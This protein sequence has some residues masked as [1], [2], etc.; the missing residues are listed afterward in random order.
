MCI[1]CSR[2]TIPIT[3]TP[4]VDKVP[5]SAEQQMYSQVADPVNKKTK[6]TLGA[7]EGGIY[8]QEVGVIIAVGL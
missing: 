6:K 7:R 1:K 2:Q 5:V 4:P 8:S 3:H